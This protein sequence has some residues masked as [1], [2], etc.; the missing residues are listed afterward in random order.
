MSQ[1]AILGGEPARKEPYPNWP[2]FD[3]REVEA[4]TEVVRSGRW[5]GFP[6]PARRRL[7][8]SSASPR[9][10]AAGTRS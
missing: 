8:S 2:V 1:L 10:R 5:G 3:E 9:C 6:T 7:N 4:V